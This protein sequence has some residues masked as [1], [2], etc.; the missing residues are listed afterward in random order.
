MLYRLHI[1]GSMK[2]IYSK[3]L[4]SLYFLLFIFYLY[5]YISNP[6]ILLLEMSSPMMEFY[7]AFTMLLMLYV[8]YVHA[9]DKFRP[10]SLIL[11]FIVVNIFICAFISIAMTVSK[12]FS[13]MSYWEIFCFISVYIIVYFPLFLAYK[14][15]RNRYLAKT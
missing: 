15:I 3:S 1:G 11:K 8:L 12:D 9:F 14:D 4:L 7:A 2:V 10:K 13:L 5:S 6:D